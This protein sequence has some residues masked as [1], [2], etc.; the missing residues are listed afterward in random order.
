M[1]DGA[2]IFKLGDKVV[3]KGDPEKVVFKVVDENKGYSARFKGTVE[4]E[5]ADDSSL[6]SMDAVPE[7]LLEK[8][9]EPLAAGDVI[10][11]AD[12][13]IFIV[14]KNGHVHEEVYAY[15]EETPTA[16]ST[17]LYEL[18]RPIKKIGRVEIDKSL[19]K[20]GDDE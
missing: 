6:P 15:V 2:Q 1:T 20:D 13:I 10:Q 9:P 18:P 16:W 7:R 8:A 3:F 4:L 12:G 17:K 14:G 19:L 11:D 5:L